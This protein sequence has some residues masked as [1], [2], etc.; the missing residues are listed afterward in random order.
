MGIVEYWVGMGVG[1]D[2]YLNVPQQT[3]LELDESTKRNAW[4]SFWDASPWRAANS[5][6]C[7]VVWRDQYFVF[8]YAS[9]V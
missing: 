1:L 4:R 5:E 8:L 2:I 6:E 9:P 7:D 3:K